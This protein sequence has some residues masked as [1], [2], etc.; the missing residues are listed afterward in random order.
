M[1]V[2]LCN[3]VTVFMQKFVKVQNVSR[4]NPFIV[5]GSACVLLGREGKKRAVG[6]CLGLFLVSFGRD[7]PPF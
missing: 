4:L 1:L 5:T 7:F 3:T 2:V 6:I